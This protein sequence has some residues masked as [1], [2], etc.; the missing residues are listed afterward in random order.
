MERLDD[1]KRALTVRKLNED[2]WFFEKDI[3]DNSKINKESLGK[4]GLDLNLRAFST[5]AIDFI[6]KIENLRKNWYKL[7]SFQK[8]FFNLKENDATVCLGNSENSSLSETTNFQNLK[9]LEKSNLNSS[10]VENESKLLVKNVNRMI[11]DH[12]NINSLQN[13]FEM[14]NGCIKGNVDILLIFET[15]LSESFPIG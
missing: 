15:K 11:I 7:G 4:K 10:S 8:S 6:K 12:I 5:L 13:K 2:L 3:F 14:L 9:D 1:G